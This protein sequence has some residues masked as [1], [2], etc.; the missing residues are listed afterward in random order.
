M[1]NKEIELFVPGRLCIMGEHSDWAGRYRT[2]NNSIEKGYAIVTGIEEG[3]YATVKASDKLIVKFKKDESKHFETEMD[4]K[5][6]KK[7]A[8]S[9]DFWCYIAGVAS[10]VKEQYNVGGLE[11]VINDVTIPTKKG[12]SSSASICV[13]VAR[14]FNK[15]YNL[16]LNTIGE[17]NIAYNGEIAT[18]SRCGKLDQACA[19]G[20]KPILMTFDGDKLNIKN[21]KIS[22][23]LYF[24]FADLM[25]QKNTIKILG[26]LN[27]C[28]PF[29]QNELEENVQSGL[30]ELNKQIIFDSLKCIEDGDVEALGKLMIK[31]QE[32][33]DK[34]VAPACPQELT[35]PVLHKVLND[36]N[37]LK[38]SYGCKGVGSQGDGTVQF[39][40]KDKESQ[41]L[42][43]K[44]LEEKLNLPAYTLTINKTKPVTKAII[45][46]AGNGTRMYPITKLLRK[47]FLP[48]ID[49]D[50]M[51]K[52]AIMSILEE[53]DAAGIEQICLII[54]ED[55]QRDYDK[56]FN[57]KLSDEHVAKLSSEMLDYE[58]KIRKIGKKLRYVYQKDKLG[59]GHAVS[60]CEEFAGDD[61]VLLVLGDQLYMTTNNKSCTEQI[62]ENFSETEKLTVSVCEVNLEDVCKYGILSGT[63]EEGNDYFMVDKM[64][65]KPEE[66]YAKEYLYTKVNNQK[67]Y[68]S[69]FGE[70][71]LTPEV[72]KELRRNI[73][74]G[75]KEK[76]EFQLTTALDKVREKQ[77]MI[78]FIPDGEM[79]DIGTVD[80]YKKTLIKKMK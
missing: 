71:I 36:E 8:E 14:A 59:L 53:I 48:I 65:E 52:P 43:K 44:Y 50:G 19:F 34:Y 10:Y 60:L 27:K 72:F 39:L 18:P 42:I 35:S 17:M 20:K 56:F 58:R 11:I 76:G 68:F 75:Y 61:P 24:V 31:A 46:V 57:Q 80:S 79:L 15:I 26:D 73:E 67:K 25:A 51:V 78:S 62:L 41:E 21:I 12:L 13:L 66:S 63:I 54:D 3:I 74:K 45:P 32:I 7:I 30:G 22:N 4:L 37:L 38:L 5:E 29:A 47:A 9:G 64:Y 28:F 23:D 40:A 70:Y 55:D 77:G 49:G 33:F 2:V 6:L 16:H 69:V 1:K